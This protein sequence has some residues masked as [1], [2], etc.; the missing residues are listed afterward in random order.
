MSVKKNVIKF[1]VTPDKSIMIVGFQEGYKE[2]KIFKIV[3]LG[4]SE[5]KNLLEITKSRDYATPICF[6]NGTNKI[7]YNCYDGIYSLDYNTFEKKKLMAIL[8]IWNY[9]L[10]HQINML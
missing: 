8:M 1:L 2:T 3:N 4:N 7:K 5:I 9:K 10:L 6:V